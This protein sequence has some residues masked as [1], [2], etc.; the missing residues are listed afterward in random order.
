[1][2][3][4]GLKDAGYEYI[5]LD[6]GWMVKDHRDKNGDLIPDPVK[7]PRNESFIRLCSF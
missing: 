3:S 6:D 5:V 4:S 7:F 1:M 2:V